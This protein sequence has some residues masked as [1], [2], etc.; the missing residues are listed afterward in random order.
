MASK[1]GDK[2]GMWTEEVSLSKF[3]TNFETI[4][5]N[6]NDDSLDFYRTFSII[7]QDLCIMCK[8]VDLVTSRKFLIYLSRNWIVFYFVKNCIWDLVFLYMVSTMNNIRT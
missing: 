3:T 2:L 8:I 7:F 4:H 1:G 6:V 5:T